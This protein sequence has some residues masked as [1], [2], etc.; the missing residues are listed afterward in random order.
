MTI[1]TK[2]TSVLAL[3]RALE[4]PQGCLEKIEGAWWPMTAFPATQEMEI[5]RIK[6]QGQP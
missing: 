5:R 1:F 4:H 6:V 3:H 2:P